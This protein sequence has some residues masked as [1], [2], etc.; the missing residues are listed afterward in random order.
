M[1]I[2]VDLHEQ[3]QATTSIIGCHSEAFPV[4][5][6]FLILHLPHYFSNSVTADLIESI[7]AVLWVRNNSLL[8]AAQVVYILQEH[9]T[10]H[11]L[12]VI[13]IVLD[14]YSTEKNL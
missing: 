14:E 4:L 12:P 8:I 2:A 7:F 5:F 9:D 6:S 10:I 13:N 11:F 1:K 3:I